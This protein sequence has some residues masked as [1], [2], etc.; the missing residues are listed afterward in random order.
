MMARGYDA[1]RDDV[2]EW[3]RPGPLNDE[4]VEMLLDAIEARLDEAT[5]SDA[6]SDRALF[7]DLR[8]FHV[9]TDADREAIG[10]AREAARLLRRMTI[11]DYEPSGRRAV[12]DAAYIAANALTDADLETLERLA[13]EP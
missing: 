5:D 8:A 4:T 10:R 13:G 11:G 6:V 1:D 9:V 2:P 3:Y 12:M 7:R